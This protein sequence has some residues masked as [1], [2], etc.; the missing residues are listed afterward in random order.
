[1]PPGRS[2]IT[3]SPL[4]QHARA[5][6]SRPFTRR[7]VAA[8]AG[9]DPTVIHD[10]DST[11][12]D[13]ET[14][15]ARILAFIEGSSRE[16]FDTLARA[17][18]RY[19]YRRNPSYRRFVDRL[20][21]HEPATW[22]DLPAVPADAFKESVLACAPAARVYRSSGTT[23]GHA[24]RSQH[25]VPTLAL[26]R[27]SALAGFRAAVLP[28]DA[29]RPFVVAAPERATH[30]ESSLGEMV[31]WLRDA[32]DAGGR[33]SALG[34]DGL[35]LAAFI[36]ALDAVE[37]SQPILLVAVTSALLRL[38]DHAA[39][40][41]RRWNLP[42]GSL[43]MDTGGCKGYATDVPRST[44][45]A[46]YAETLGVGADAVVNE[47]GMTELCSQFYAWGDGPFRSPPWVRTAAVD[48]ETGR[49]LPMG[50]RG[51]LRHVDLANLGSV[52]AVQT[53]DVG[54]VVDD[55]LLLE[56]RLRDA[57]ARGCSLLV[58]R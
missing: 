18:H 2:N 29:R 21:R 20:A 45:L 46:R 58:A 12:T 22:L 54:R 28:P 52:L 10:I 9:T 31:S 41:G 25:H 24:H 33:P 14:L 32:H 23:A 1:M 8:D 30:P 3:H 11:T 50:S 19:Q 27:T 43:V 7:I 57:D 53:E 56:G 39:T 26:Y 13:D 37:P 49:I 38:A 48:P 47:Y 34:A 4:R 55:G 5:S 35:D 42:A 36:A 6:I 40:A 51:L 15:S 17:G 44:I 16:D